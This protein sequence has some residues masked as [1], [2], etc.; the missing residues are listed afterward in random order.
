MSDAVYAARAKPVAGLAFHLRPYQVDLRD[1]ARAE[2]RMNRRVLVQAPTGSGKTRIFSD[3]C[4]RAAARGKRVIIT[5]HRAEI[6]RQISRALIDL[7][8]AHGM[9]KPGVAPTAHS[10]QIA[11]VQTLA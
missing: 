3:I 2:M 1:G 5:A 9:I 8:V 7:G 11:M 10:V 6:C 4:A